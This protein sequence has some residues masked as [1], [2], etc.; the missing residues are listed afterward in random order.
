[1]YCWDSG[2]KDSEG[3][4]VDFDVAV[5][6]LNQ[7]QSMVF[8]I[9]DALYYAR[10]FWNDNTGGVSPFFDRSVRVFC[11]TTMIAASWSLPT[12]PPALTSGT[13]P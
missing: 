5:Y 1:L 13:T 8:N 12:T 6:R 9:A 3:G 11:S 10:K 7:I 2:T 4:T